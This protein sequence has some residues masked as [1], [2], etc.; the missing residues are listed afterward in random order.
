MPLPPSINYAAT[1]LNKTF[2]AFLK[3]Y[4]HSFIIGNQAIVFMEKF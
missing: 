3:R 4:K 1:L 2:N